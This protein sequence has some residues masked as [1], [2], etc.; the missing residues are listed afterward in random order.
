MHSP[1][2]RFLGRLLRGADVR[3]FSCR[4]ASRPG[5]RMLVCY[6]CRRGARRH[7]GWRPKQ[8]CATLAMKAGF[9]SALQPDTGHTERRR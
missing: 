8:P 1:A 4:I 6:L 2:G 3:H 7:H 9:D 5:M